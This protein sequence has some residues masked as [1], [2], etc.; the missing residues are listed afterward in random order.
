MENPSSSNNDNGP[1]FNLQKRIFQRV[2]S[3]E[4][5]NQ[6]IEIIRKA[7]EDAIDS[8]NIELSHAE[9]KQLQ[10]QILR[11][12]LEGIIEKLGNNSLSV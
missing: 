1:Y 7:Y 4:L 8:E 5:D 10:S 11:L 12:V 3:S 2:R 9:R 6:I